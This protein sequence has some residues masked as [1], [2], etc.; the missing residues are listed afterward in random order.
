[1][2]TTGEAYLQV[3]KN[4]DVKINFFAMLEKALKTISVM[5]YGH[6]Q[7]IQIYS[8]LDE[9]CGSSNGRTL[10]LLLLVILKMRYGH[11]IQFNVILGCSTE[12]L[13][14]LGHDQL[15]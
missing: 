13:Q 15:A 7:P 10:Y 5:R 12:P 11:R 6:F 1:M 4:A 9:Q 3:C 8:F 14:L 2:N